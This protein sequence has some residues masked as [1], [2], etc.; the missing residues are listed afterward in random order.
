MKL[1]ET[2][3]RTLKIDSW[4]DKASERGRATSVKGARGSCSVLKGKKRRKLYRLS[5]CP[6]FPLD[7]KKFQMVSKEEAPKILAQVF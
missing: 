5:G 4:K 6:L 3:Q 1:S 7:P 2:Y